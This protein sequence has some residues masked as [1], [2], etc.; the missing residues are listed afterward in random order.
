L[1]SLPKYSPNLAPVEMVFSFVKRRLK[2]ITKEDVMQ[3]S[4]FVSNAKMLE[5]FKG[6]DGDTVKRFFH[7]FYSK[8]RWNI[9]QTERV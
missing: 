7:S 5:A 1:V 3:L 9:R 6:L 8:M 2:H 4:S